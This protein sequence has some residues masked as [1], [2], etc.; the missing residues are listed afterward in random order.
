MNR[1]RLRALSWL[2]APAEA[3]YLRDNELGISY[4]REHA[5]AIYRLHFGRGHQSRVRELSVCSIDG[6]YR[7][8]AAALEVKRRHGSNMQLRPHKEWQLN[9]RLWRSNESEVPMAAWRRA[10]DRPG[11]STI[12]TTCQRLSACC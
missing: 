4:E 3:A 5:K 6:K 8:S 12:N 11:S 7:A 2:S 9:D 10:C 1:D